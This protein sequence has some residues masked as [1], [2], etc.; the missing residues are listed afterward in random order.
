MCTTHLHHSAGLLHCIIQA[1]QSS[2]S[3]TFLRACLPVGALGGRRHSRSTTLTHWACR[4]RAATCTPCSRWGQAIAD[5]L[6]MFAG[7][8]SCRIWSQASRRSG[9]AGEALPSYPKPPAGLL[10]VLKRAHPNLSTTPPACLPGLPAC[11]P[12]CPTPFNHPLQACTQPQFTH[13]CST[14][15][16]NCILTQTQHP[17]CRCAPS[18]ARSSPRWALRRCPPTTTWSPPSG[19]LMPCSSRSSTQP[20][21]RTTPSSSQVSGGGW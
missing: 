19:T 18:S 3:I 8:C 10:L 1:H 13:T 12:S 7:G 6:P 9:D 21:T 16:L 11:L 14:S 2:R 20:A 15:C 5:H 17:P 4:P